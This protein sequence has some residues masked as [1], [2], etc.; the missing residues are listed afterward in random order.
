MFQISGTAT[1]KAIQYMKATKITNV[2]LVVNHFLKQNIWRIIS[3]EYMKDTKI[4][5]EGGTSEALRLK[6][7]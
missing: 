1:V 5:K 2:N 7:H 3:I 6:P 4:S